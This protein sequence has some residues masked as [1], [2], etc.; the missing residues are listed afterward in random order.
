[1]PIMKCPA[2]GSV[3]TQAASCPNCGHLAPEIGQR[4][5]F[6]RKPSKEEIIAAAK[7]AIAENPNPS[8]EQIFAGINRGIAESERAGRPVSRK[9]R[10]LLFAIPIVLAIWPIGVVIWRIT[11]ALTRH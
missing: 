4:N 3:S 8:M 2:C 11:H 6:D 7:R 1:M 10:V 5:S 9:V